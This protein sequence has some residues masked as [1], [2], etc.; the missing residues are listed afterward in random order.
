MRGNLVR[1]SGP[2]ASGRLAS[3]RD[4]VLIGGGHAHVQV[5]RRWMMNPVDDVKLTVVLD[6]P[7]AVYSGMVPGFVAGDY[8]A[9]ELEIDVVPLA[10]RA[11][12]RCILARATLVNPSLQRIEL[13][14][15]APIRYDL[16]SLDVGSSIVGLDL[17]GVREHAIATRP[18]R[19]FIHE[20]DARLPREQQGRD[21]T[22]P[23]RI[24][25]V[26][27]GAAGLELAFTVRARLLRSG[28]SA[29]ISIFCQ[30]DDV[31]PRYSARFRERV[32][33]EARQRGIRVRRGV[34]VLAVEKD[35][36]V[37]ANE[38]VRSD[39]TLFATGAAPLPLLGRSPLPLDE[40]GFVRVDANLEVVG[41][42]GLFAVGDCASLV[43]YPWV[44]KA[45]VYAVREAP[46]LDHNL[47]ARLRADAK[48][49]PYR[50]QRDFLA[51]LNLGEGL[52]LGA[53]WQM[54]AG[55][56]PVWML[57]DWI[58]RRFMKRFQVLEEDGAD[59]ADFPSPE[60]MG[61]EEMPCGGCAAKVGATSLERAL[62]RLPE[63]PADPTVLLGLD[64][65]DDAA[66]LAQPGGDVVLATVD[67]FRG[68]TD[69]PWLVG[70]VAAVNAASDVL[71]KGGRP[72]HALALVNVPEEDPEH[73]EETLY[74]VLSGVRAALDEL[75][76][77]LVGGH[78]TTGDALYV[79]LSIMGE[80]GP[81]GEVIRIDGLQPD[82]RLILTKPL[83]TGVVLAADMQGRARG[84]WLRAVIA[85][86]LRTN[87]AAAAVAIEYR[88]SACTDISG[89]G[90]A[91]HLGEL[92]RASA[93]SASIELDAIP[94][95]PGALTLFDR[96]LRSTF[97]AQNRNG[98]RGLAIP[99]ALAQH[100][101]IE[102]L[103]DPQTS[104][105]LL[106]S[107][108]AERAS[109]ALTAL[110]DAGQSDSAIVGTVTERR[111]DAALFEVT[112][113]SASAVWRNRPH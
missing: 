106:L 67:A 80:P 62:S 95:L 51:L 59:A 11:R 88:A 98:C 22:A 31:L 89:F 28:R 79:G 66:A 8:T 75:G 34:E 103:F 25:V 72:R 92:L 83:G 41:C 16:A 39:L 32:L 14:G 70:R 45:G 21:G 43:S 82:D 84:A 58:D 54:V 113:A 42:K 10:R 69:D 48:L 6:V 71:A 57:K 90:F 81:A 24:T 13:E 110:R 38:R 100:P 74:Q 26:G 96:G 111:S 107:V 18:I 56:R 109:A 9:R 93:V 63:A 99:D 37:L 44:A 12:A 19:S 52:A 64:E 40:R 50:P 77:S 91:G 36:V 86:M 108:A 85:S 20:L 73:A 7:E 104:G 3:M 94:A 23:L 27:A 68:F 76:I 101:A 5:L 61:M 4:L 1:L 55:G 30:S 65:P 105:G 53:K 35:A 2:A 29:E 17:P 97:H 33:R 60:A 47:R 87:A 46:Y 78:S 112:L 102:L 15:R 49:H